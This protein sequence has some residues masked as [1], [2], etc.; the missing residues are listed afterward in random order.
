MKSFKIY[1]FT[2]TTI[3]E[4]EGYKSDDLLQPAQ[5]KIDLKQIQIRKVRLKVQIKM[6]KAQIKKV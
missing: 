5:M 3:R 4:F 1:L 2:A 6:I